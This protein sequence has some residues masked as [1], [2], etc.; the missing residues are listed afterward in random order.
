MKAISLTLLTLG[1]S[2]VAASDL[3]RPQHCEYVAGQAF[4]A[5]PALAA[6]YNKE[7]LLARIEDDTQQNLSLRK[8]AV[9]AVHAYVRR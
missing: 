9:T 1:G 6:A 8:D 4:L 2:T 3:N 7:Q 5:H